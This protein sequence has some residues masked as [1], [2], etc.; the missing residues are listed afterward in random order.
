VEWDLYRRE[1]GRLIAKGHEGKHVLIKGEEILGI[2]ET[3]NDALD[4]GY[5]R[6]LRTGFFVHH[7]QTWERVVRV[8]PYFWMSCRTQHSPSTR[9]DSSCS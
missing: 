9:T 7:I 3:H 8:S 1:V 6:F 4:E 2:F 5:R